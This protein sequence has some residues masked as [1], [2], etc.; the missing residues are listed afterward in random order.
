MGN[1][2]RLWAVVIGATTET[3][4]S[5]PKSQDNICGKHGPF[6]SLSLKWP[7][8]GADKNSKRRD[9][10]PTPDQPWPMLFRELKEMVRCLEAQGTHPNAE[11]DACSPAAWF[12]ET[13]AAEKGWKKR[14]AEAWI[15]EYRYKI[16]DAMYT[17]G[18]EFVLWLLDHEEDQYCPG[19]EGHVL[20][21]QGTEPNCV[22]R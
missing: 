8:A 19:C 11:V 4:F 13:L 7:V 22:N 20:S 2:V 10:M 21:C 1:P 18:R 3:P 15:F 12:R 14:D 9:T 17:A 16:Q 6:R 5:T